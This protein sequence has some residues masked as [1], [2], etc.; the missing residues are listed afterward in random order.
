M[1]AL[2]YKKNTRLI[3][4]AFK[5]H[6]EIYCL[7]FFKWCKLNE[8]NNAIQMMCSR[9]DY[10]PVKSFAEVVNLARMKDFEG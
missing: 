10:G 1:F 3:V 5:K 9:T 6:S 4:D 2:F 8:K 7:Q